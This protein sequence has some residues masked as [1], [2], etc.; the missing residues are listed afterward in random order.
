MRF[1]VLL[2]PAWAGLAQEI[3]L[4][5]V[6]TGISQPTDI[7]ADGSGRLF[8]VQQNGVIRL[9]KNGAIIPSP[10]LDI[11]SRT[12]SSGECGLLGLAFPPGFAEKQ[13][14]YVNYTEPG[15]RLSVVARYRVSSDS[16]SADP[17]SEERI[18][19]QSQPFANHN[20]GQ[21]AFG[22][23]GYLY[24]G[25]G[26]G[27]SGGDPQNN[28]QGKRTWLG[29]M[30]RID[31]ESDLNRYRVP[32]TNPFVRDDPWLPEIWSYGLRNPWRYSFDRETGDLWIGDVGQNRAEE[33]S[34][35][36]ASSRGGE[37]YGWRLMEGLQCYS[38][39]PNCD[40]TGLTLPLIEYT[41]QRGDVS[42][43]GGF[44][45]RGSRFPALRGTYL[46]ADYA[47][48]RMWG[49]TWTGG[50]VQNRLL[51]ESR[52]NISTF[53]Q[54]E[55]GELYVGDH[56]GGGIYRIESTNTPRLSISSLVNPASREPGAV[57][58]S[59]ATIFVT[60]AKD[61]PGVVQATQLPLPTT[62]DG[63]SA[64]VNGRTAP[65]QVLANVDGAE[66][67]NLQIPFETTGPA[68][69][70]SVRRGT[71]TSPE[72]T[73]QLFPVQ[74]G[75]FANANGE[76]ILVRVRDISLV[77]AALPLK[78]DEL[79]CLYA[80]GLGAVDH[81]PVSGDV[82]S[83]IE[84]LARAR[85]NIS[86]A[87]GGVPCE[88]QYAGLAPGLAGIYQ[89]TIRTAAGIGAGPKDLVLSANG[90]QSRPVRVIVE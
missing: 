4:V 87:I 70:V 21:L 22:P 83:W 58:G 74:P 56:G 7:Q 18:L 35:Q 52:R 5:Q 16:D 77:S 60:G 26:D 65:L 44:V 89:V 11:R 17:A 84:P 34:F 8:F 64:T 28:G 53:G 75:I 68:A 61:S 27:G 25:F 10:F 40:Q 47:T 9:F 66:Y 80:T 54:D 57:A 13:Y 51:L 37:N 6:A 38:P 39:S 24:I 41:R 90:A 3:S 49:I 20:G 33:V 43:T 23:D 81:P 45:Y 71:V 1:V 88:V 69:S 63:V 42:V 19:T 73:V 31:T 67:I 36:P 79:Y 14:F 82:A 15:C 2:L 62:L 29:K 55:N 85:A 76:A 78:R 12:Q 59:L 72:V 48:G 50:G 30:L 32:D 46:Y 86:I